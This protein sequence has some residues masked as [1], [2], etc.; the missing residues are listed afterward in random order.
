M[1]I[2]ILSVYCLATACAAFAQ[3]PFP[4]SLS[5]SAQNCVGTTL[6][7]GTPNTAV[8]SKITWFKDNTAVQTNEAF[9]IAGTGITIA[10][11]NGRGTNANQL[12]NP[13]AVF[14]D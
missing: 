1:K 3:C 4:V 2:A 10:G 14:V 7:I 12:N 6:N 5:G 11:L 9:S 8:L 13:I